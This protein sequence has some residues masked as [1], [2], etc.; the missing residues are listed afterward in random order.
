MKKLLYTFSTIILTIS[1]LGYSYIYEY[2]FRCKNYDE[3]KSSLKTE[4]TGKFGRLWTYARNTTEAD[5]AHIISDGI[6]YCYEYGGG[7][8]KII[9]KRIDHEGNVEEQKDLNPE[10]DLPSRMMNNCLKNLIEGKHFG[11]LTESCQQFLTTPYN[12]QCNQDNE[13]C[14]MYTK[15]S[16]A[17]K[18]NCTCD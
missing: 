7:L 12:I 11:Y 6:K 16:G 13:N 5:Y 14:K 17:V 4:A 15:T 9:R 2:T 8:N 10:K 1:N 3:F 18:D